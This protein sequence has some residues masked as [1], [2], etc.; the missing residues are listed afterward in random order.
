MQQSI[1]LDWIY[2]FK[3]FKDNIAIL[4]KDD[5][6]DHNNNNPKQIFANTKGYIGFRA[7]IPSP[8][9]WPKFQHKMGCIPSWK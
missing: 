4:F 3:I 8:H 5:G 2:R 7:I 6:D 1:I 9:L